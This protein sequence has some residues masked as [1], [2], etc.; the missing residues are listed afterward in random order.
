MCV[1]G[2]L[3]YYLFRFFC[4]RCRQRQRQRRQRSRRATWHFF[5]FAL[6]IIRCW[7]QSPHLCLWFV[8]KVCSR[9]IGNDV[10]ISN[11]ISISGV[12]EATN[13]RIA[14]LNAISRHYF[15]TIRHNKQKEPYAT[16]TTTT[17]C[18]CTYCLHTAIR[19]RTATRR[20]CCAL[21]CC[22]NDSRAQYLPFFVAAA[23]VS[24]IAKQATCNRLERTAG[25]V[26]AYSRN[27][28]SFFSACVCAGFRIAC[29]TTADAPEGSR[30]LKCRFIS[31]N[32]FRKKF[33]STW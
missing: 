8:H 5:G 12:A 4:E 21:E 16:T 6:R 20:S 27:C 29:N 31:V 10:V 24:D 7:S 9:S 26:T 22:S 2:L 19:R 15:L 30:A 28:F 11:S 17:T 32:K 3:D 25:A 18:V 1:H 33:L 13:D 14:T 23:A